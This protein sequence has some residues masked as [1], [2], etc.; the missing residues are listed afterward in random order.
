MG[1]TSVA[2]SAGCPVQ[3]KCWGVLRD[4]GRKGSIGMGPMQA[5]GV[6]VG[7]IQAWR[8]DRDDLLYRASGEALSNPLGGG[9]VWSEAP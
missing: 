4:K 8:L 1:A 9:K 6:I 3:R 7:M 5:A 2:R